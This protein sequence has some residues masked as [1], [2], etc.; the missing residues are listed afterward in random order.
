MTSEWSFE[1]KAGMQ[2]FHEAPFEDIIA[3][4]F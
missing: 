2:L 4:E 3:S 1:E